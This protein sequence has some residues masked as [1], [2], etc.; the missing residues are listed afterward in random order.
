MACEESSSKDARKSERHVA[1]QNVVAHVVC[2]ALE[3]RRKIALNPP[4]KLSDR[5][6]CHPG[7]SPKDVNKAAEFLDDLCKESR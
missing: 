6:C 7:I 2:E 5:D 3:F 4:P 1:D